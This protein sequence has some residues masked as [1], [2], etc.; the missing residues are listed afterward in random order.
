MLARPAAGHGSP[1]CPD[2]RRGLS[3]GLLRVKVTSPS[4]RSKRLKPKHSP[5]L[6]PQP[7]SLLEP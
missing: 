4:G 2:Q 1:I 7:M 3:R 6:H 5:R